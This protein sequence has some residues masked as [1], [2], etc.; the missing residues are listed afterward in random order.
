MILV[1]FYVYEYYKKDTGEVF[2]VGKGTGRRMYE[3]H[4]RNRYFN[5]VYRKYECDVRVYKDGLTNA[6]ACDIERQ[7]I[8]ELKSINQAYCNFTEGGTGFSTGKLNPIHKRIREGTVKLFDGSQK[9]YGEDNGFYGRK[10]S[11]ETRRKI[12]ESRKG[13]GGQPGKLNPMYGKG[14]KGKD[15]PMYGRTRENHPNVK[16]YTVTYTNGTKE[17]L[18]YK[19]CEKKFGI[20]FLRVQRGG[21]LHYKK[22]SK[23]DI[24]EGTMIELERVTT[25]REA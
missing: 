20:A 13:K 6:E 25:S 18:T 2:Y 9:F 3:L 1:S 4:N 14:L 5:A 16:M 24:Y 17:L 23:N 21:I 8:A 15:N 19:E 10:H 7:R 22:K 12:S 11:E